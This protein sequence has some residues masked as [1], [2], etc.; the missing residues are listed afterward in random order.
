M[1]PTLDTDLDSVQHN[2]N[3]MLTEA[4]RMNTLYKDVHH[5]VLKADEPKPS[6]A[7]QT[8]FISELAFIGQ[9]C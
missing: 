4:G 2:V 3:Y 6:C 8:H 9:G 5:T 7:E 1:L